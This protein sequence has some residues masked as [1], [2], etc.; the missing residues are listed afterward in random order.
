MT[1][2][3]NITLNATP[4]LIEA[5]RRF[6]EALTGK[7][8]LNESATV[9]A[10]PVKV[11]PLTG[12][13]SEPVV[14]EPVVQTPLNLLPTPVNP[15]QTPVN[16]VPVAAA[17]SYTLDALSRAGALLAQS[18]KMEQALALLAKYRIQSVNQLN[19]EQYGAFATELRALGAQI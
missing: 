3:I 15:V 18:G 9:Y 5:I 11:E 1:N 17:P 13:A 10:G 12:V 8:V 19:P 2:G 7:P 6:A 16:P 14:V 4:E